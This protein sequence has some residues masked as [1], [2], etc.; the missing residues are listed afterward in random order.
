VGLQE[1][2]TWLQATQFSLVIQSIE[3]IVPLLQSVHILLIGVVFVSVLMIA[4][5]V[6]GLAR[7]EESLA[8]VWARFAPFLWGGLLLMAVTGVLLTISEPLRELM[9]I[10][11]RLK[12]LLLVI[13]ITSA[14]LFGHSVRRGIRGGTL[15]PVRLPAGIRVAAA[16]T[17]V[18]WL[19]V[20]FLGRAIAYDDS[21]W[22]EWSPAVLQGADPQ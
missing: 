5:R 2:A 9:T 15:D 21:I 22:G 17:I 4:L 18:L 6:L 14:A 3:W 13:G 8:A 7:T 10:S 20:I 1:F 19:A 11:F 16:C 12:M